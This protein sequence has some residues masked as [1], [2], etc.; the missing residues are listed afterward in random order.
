MDQTFFNSTQSIRNIHFTSHKLCVE[1]I[2]LADDGKLS[3]ALNMFTKAIETDPSNHIAY[4]NRATIKID[5]G[6]IEGARNDFY[7]FDSFRT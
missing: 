7:H 3:E 5:L 2:T 1:G 6:D 4:Y